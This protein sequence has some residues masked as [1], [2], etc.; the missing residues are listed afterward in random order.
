MTR[1]LTPNEVYVL[2]AALRYQLPRQTYGSG[3]V[4]DEIVRNI[5]GISH[6]D[7]DKMFTEIM[8]AYNR[9]EVSDA[10]KIEWNRALKALWTKLN[11]PRDI[12]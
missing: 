4:A 10:D 11:N 2:F 6:N 5:D 12:R 1:L 9:E 7:V 3:I 8:E